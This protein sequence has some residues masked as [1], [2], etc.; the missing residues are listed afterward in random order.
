MFLENSIGYFEEFPFNS[1]TYTFLK[2]YESRIILLGLVFI[3][4]GIEYFSTFKKPTKLSIVSKLK[5]QE[6]WQ[7]VEDAIFGHYKVVSC[8]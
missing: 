6:V 2:R 4:V 5:Q 7:C 1:Q 8:I 3:R